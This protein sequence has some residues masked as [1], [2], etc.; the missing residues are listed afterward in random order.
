[1]ATELPPRSPR[2]RTTVGAVVVGALLVVA[3]VVAYLASSG[4]TPA[5]PK[6]VAEVVRPVVRVVPPTPPPRKPV[7][8]VPHDTVTPSAP[9]YFTLTG[10]GWRVWANVCSMAPVFPIDPPGEQHHTV[11]WITAGFGVA[12]GSDTMTSYIFGHAWAEDSDEVLNPASE[13]ATR[14]ILHDTPHYVSGIATYP[15]PSL[16]GARIT[17]R[18]ATGTL[19]YAVHDAFGASKAQV[20]NIPSVMDQTVKNRVVVVTCAELGGVDYNY[21]IVLDAYLV[22]SIANHK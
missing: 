3:A 13:R 12:P 19:I 6:P 1:M 16:V 14:D 7:P 5:K 4:G 22:E 18:T 17:L 8:T 15:A 20:G 10:L 21:D 11:C 9:T 2:R